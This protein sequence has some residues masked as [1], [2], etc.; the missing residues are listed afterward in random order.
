MSVF[1]VLLLLLIKLKFYSRSIRYYFYDTL[2]K[3]L[4]LRDLSIQND[5]RLHFTS[6]LSFYL[7]VYLSAGSSMAIKYTDDKRSKLNFN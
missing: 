3:L 6:C 2:L 7:K 4:N 5:F 1:C